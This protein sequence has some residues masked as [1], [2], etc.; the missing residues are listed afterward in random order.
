MNLKQ[1][2]IDEKD[3][4]HFEEANNFDSDMSKLL[5]RF[6]MAIS[7]VLTTKKKFMDE[8]VEDTIQETAKKISMTITEQLEAKEK[9]VKGFKSEF[10]SMVHQATNDLKKMKEVEDK[11]QDIH[12]LNSNHSEQY[13]TVI[14][15]IRKDIYQ[16][17]KK[18]LIETQQ[19]EMGNIR[20]HLKLTI[21]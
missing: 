18:M 16:M 12:K 5:K 20:K 11:I 10:Y 6:K 2:L 8:F 3:E 1:N 19:Q 15:G 9:T 17:Q 4:P 13:K 7:K 21:A 14:E